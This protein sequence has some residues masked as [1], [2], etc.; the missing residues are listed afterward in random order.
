MSRH[1]AVAH[2]IVYSIR[3]WLAEP[4]GIAGGAAAAGDPSALL[5][6]EAGQHRHA[7]PSSR[8]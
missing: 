8:E 4:E 2:H 7:D 3:R 5:G 6:L 1:T